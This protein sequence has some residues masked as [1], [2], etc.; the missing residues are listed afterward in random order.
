MTAD[1]VEVN[2]HPATSPV[3]GWVIPNHLDVSLEFYDADGSPVG[4]FGLEHG[5][6]RYRTRAGNIANPGDDLDRDL[7]GP[8]GTPL[9][10][11][12]LAQLMRFIRDRPAG[13]LTDL[14]ATIETSDKFINPANFA[15]DVT[16]SVLIG[17]PLA[18]VRGR[19]SLSTAGGVLPASQAST[20]AT[21]AL[22]QAVANRW[23]DYAVRQA[24]TCAGLDQVRIPVRLG[25][26]TD[27]D[28]GL[29]AFL[30][31]SADDAHPYSTVY[32]G[33]A[34]ANGTHGVVQPRPDTVTLTLNG[35]ALTFTALVD[36]RAPVHVTTG[37]LPTATMRI[38]PDQYVRAAQ[39]LAVTFTTRPVL[40]G[41]PDLR[42]P[43][44][45]VAGFG[46][47]WVAP[48][49]A[50]AQLAPQPSPDAPAYGY[51]PQRLLEGWLDLIPNPAPPGEAPGAGQNG[52]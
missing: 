49:Q 45:A 8:G 13:F 48:G 1:F 14:M 51:S 42:L 27:I 23:Y 20:T 2:D 38:P 41:G 25:D 33:A 46:W 18:I 19:A 12:H 7:V 16:L 6:S 30:P 26:L 9:V 10:N 15:Q 37:V 21:D 24:H 31:Q 28:D 32:S 52:G 11:T 40:R 50:P 44:P 17:R 36:P 35:P 47:S 5:A 39:R 3:C 43:L 34:P 4:S 22:G 29:V